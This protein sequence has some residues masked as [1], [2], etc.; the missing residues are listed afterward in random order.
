[1]LNYTIVIPARY[2]SSRLPGKPL[3]E[4]A[5]KTMIQRVYE[6][7]RQA[8]ATRVIIATDDT[9]IARCCEAFHAEVVMTSADHPSGTDRLE[10]VVRE[11]DLDDEEIVVNVQGDEPLIPPEVIDQVAQ[12]LDEHP[13]VGVA[14]LCERIHDIEQVM[15]PNIVKVVFDRFGRASYFSRAPIPWAREAFA[16]KVPHLPSR[17]EYYR[18]I[19]LYAYRVD[20]LKRF[21]VWPPSMT[22]QVERLEQLRVMSNG[23]A[24]HVD[25]ALCAL[26]G[27]V[28]TEADL[29]RVRA[30]F[31]ARD[32]S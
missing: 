26:P 11:L 25:L 7:A 4:I 6:Q 1:M 13:D 10:E 29:D 8:S 9:R 17:A 5:G 31:A 19:G 23:E 16:T 30:H 20:L 2:A 18:H 32:R 21:V 22:E 15:N 27:G 28:D 12:N 24:I 3:M 14:T